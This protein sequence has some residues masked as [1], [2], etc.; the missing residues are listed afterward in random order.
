MN[1][2]IPG[3]SSYP[4]IPKTLQMRLMRLVCMSGQNLLGTAT[5][6]CIPLIPFECQDRLVAIAAGNDHL[7]ALLCKVLK[8]NELPDDPRYA[9][10][11]ARCDNHASLK[12]TMEAV[13]KTDTADAW[14]AKFEAAG[15]P[16]EIVLNIDDTRKLEQIKVRGMVKNVGGYDV[17]GNPLNFSAYN[18]L[19]TMIPSPDL[20]NRGAQIREEFKA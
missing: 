4:P 13:L 18:S 11:V 10:N 2:P 7:F 1:L 19:G 16:T 12:K 15:V 9:S 5:T 6:S 14:R 3:V 8:L 20:D 17:P